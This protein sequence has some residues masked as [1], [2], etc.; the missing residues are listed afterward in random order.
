M[1]FRLNS[2][3]VAFLIIAL[4][5]C[6]HHDTIERADLPVTMDDSSR[7]II[8]RANV[9]AG[10][11]NTWQQ[12]RSLSFDKKTIS[13]DSTGAI[14]RELNQHFDYVLQPEFHA[15]ISYV[16]HDTAITL[17]HDGMK[18]RKLYNGKLSSKQKDIDGAWNSCFGSQYVMCMPYK[19]K[20]PGIKA[21]YEGMVT[22]LDGVPA[23]VVKASYVKGAGSNPDN[24]WYYFFEPGTGKLLAN[25][26][27]G[28]YNYWDY[29]RYEGFEKSGGLLMPVK[30]IGYT[31]D[32]LNKPLSKVSEITQS[33]IVFDKRFREDYFHIPDVP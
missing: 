24:V 2:F 30:R 23:Q 26:L 21:A 27:N 32:T 22:L 33:H 19:L 16:L 4:E 31:A 17:I 18:A 25:S 5:A 1:N 10:G 8:D 20:D 12:K 28:K 7:V 13:Y 29:T 9:Y 15:K 6:K 11:F 3:V 14:V